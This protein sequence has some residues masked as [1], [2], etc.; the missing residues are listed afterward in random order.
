MFSHQ[1]NYTK[2]PLFGAN[3]PVLGRQSISTPSEFYPFTPYNYP[4]VLLRRGPNTARI[5]TGR[6]I[7]SVEV[8]RRILIIPVATR[9]IYFT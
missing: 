5:Y 2:L 1:S 6:G 3:V 9:L 7:N 8:L 4:K